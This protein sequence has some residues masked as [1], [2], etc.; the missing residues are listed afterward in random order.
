MNWKEKL[1]NKAGFTF[2][3]LL[4]GI[5]VLGV[6]ILGIIIGYV[7]CFNINEISRNMTIAT[8]D[9]RQVIE[10]MRSLAVGPL[11]DIVIEDWTAWA[12]NNGLDSLD[13][14]QISVVFIDRDASG[15]ALD[16]DPLEVSVTVTW[17]DK[18]RARSVTL[19]S[20]ITVR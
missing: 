2:I 20:L 8:E 5:T 9:A 14:E 19:A 16:D 3:E 4:I 17:Q 18:L 13:N 11:T 1:K 15:D 10:Q 7:S 12:Q 6:A